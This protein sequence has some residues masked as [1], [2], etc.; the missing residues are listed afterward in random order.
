MKYNKQLTKDYEQAHM[1]MQTA[2]VTRD[3]YG[4]LC[5]M[6][7]LMTCAR[8]RTA[9]GY[10]I[11][12]TY[13]KIM[14]QLIIGAYTLC[15]TSN[16]PELKTFG[17]VINRACPSVANDKQAI[18]YFTSFF[19]AVRY[20]LFTDDYPDEYFDMLNAC[21]QRN[22]DGLVNMMPIVYDPETKQE[23]NTRYGKEVMEAVNDPEVGTK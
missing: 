5:A 17:S 15:D 14:P 8:Q 13:K 10:S 16:L 21:D 20:I 4:A 2:F 9:D 12:E 7:D 23:L 19:S 11:R 1:N 22:E 3:T 6:H 18:M